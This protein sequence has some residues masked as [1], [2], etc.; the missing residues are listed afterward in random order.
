[1]SG[2]LRSL[3]RAIVREEVLAVMREELSASHTPA[4]EAPRPQQRKTTPAAKARRKWSDDE[5]LELIM[6]MEEGMT[7]ARAAMKYGRSRKAIHDRLWH[8]NYGLMIGRPEPALA[9]Q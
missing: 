4:V 9:S 3:I 8:P 1:M 2:D 6:D 7:I 5:K